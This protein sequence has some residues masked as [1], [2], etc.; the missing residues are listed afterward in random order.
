M[1]KIQVTSVLKANLSVYSKGEFRFCT[2]NGETD[3]WP[4]A[5]NIQIGIMEGDIG[6]I[7]Y[8]IDNT[9]DKIRE[10]NLNRSFVFEDRPIV[11]ASFV[12]SSDVDLTTNIPSNGDTLK[13][14]KGALKTLRLGVLDE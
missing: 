9:N 8:Q 3:N 2:V 13:R 5:G 14:N 4:Q 1:E 11:V 7:F 12:E 6:V 10:V